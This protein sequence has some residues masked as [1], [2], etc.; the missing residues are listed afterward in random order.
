LQQEKVDLASVLVKNGAVLNIR[1]QYD[2]EDGSTLFALAFRYDDTEL[3]AQI[4]S[5]VTRNVFGI[6]RTTSHIL[7][8]ALIWAFR[9]KLAGGAVWDKTVQKVAQYNAGFRAFNYNRYQY[10]V[11]AKRFE[12]AAVLLNLSNSS[13]CAHI[14]RDQ[15]VR[16][17]RDM[18]ESGCPDNIA[19]MLK[20]DFKAVLK[21]RMR[22]ENLNDYQNLTD[23]TIIIRSK[24]AIVVWFADAGWTTDTQGAK[25]LTKLIDK[26]E[27]AGRPDLAKPYKA[28]RDQI[29]ARRVARELERS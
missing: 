8:R 24:P 7:E 26:L 1:N 10:I 20:R 17:V 11:K 4:F 9:K 16:F 21:E 6:D 3:F 29:V 22:P 12:D 28:R 13:T 15:V 25:I 5:C 19:K 14:C 23:D 2:G 27:Q 18:V